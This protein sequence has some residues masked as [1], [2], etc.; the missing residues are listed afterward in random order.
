MPKTEYFAANLRRLVDAEGGV[1]RAVAALG[2][3]RTQF[4]RYLAGRALP[5][6]AL[7]A[8]L[9]AHFRVPEIALFQRPDRPISQAEPID[10][11]QHPILRA[12]VADTG[13]IAGPKVVRDGRYLTYFYVPSDEGM[14]VRAITFVSMLGTHQ[15]FRRLTG[16]HEP[17]SSRWRFSRGRNIG[18]VVES[19]GNCFFLGYERGSVAQPSLL[20]LRLAQTGRPLL[21]GQA[22]IT[23][24]T[25]PTV[26]AVVMEHQDAVM[27]LPEVL[28]HCATTTLKDRS[29]DTD[30]RVLLQEQLPG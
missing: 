18:V 25:G 30:I 4:H 7:V 21:A 6:P 12:I 3:N 16:V 15:V 17:E 8:S 9:A 29:I 14:I 19:R 24:R 5:R 13:N 10:L 22:I 27:S 11:S 1:S 23:A 26:A 20:T 28:R 2:I